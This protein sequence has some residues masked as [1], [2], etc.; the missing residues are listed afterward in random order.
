MAAQ[1][2]SVV[3]GGVA[4]TMNLKYLVYNLVTTSVVLTGLDFHSHTVV[5][6]DIFFLALPTDCDVFKGTDAH[7]VL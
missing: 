1:S 3:E 2:D 4:V 5:R 6:K 7:S